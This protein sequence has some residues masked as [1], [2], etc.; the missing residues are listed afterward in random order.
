MG[1][2]GH[3]LYPRTQAFLP[4]R[5]SLAVLLQA[6]NAVGVSV[7]LT[8]SPVASSWVEKV[9]V[10]SIWFGHLLQMVANTADLQCTGDE[11]YSLTQRHN[12]G[13]TS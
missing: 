3:E 12:G 2:C 7:V 9:R 4:Q 5:L 11:C 10:E 6:T 13:C 1:R 8:Y